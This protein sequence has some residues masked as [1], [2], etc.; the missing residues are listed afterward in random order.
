M[1]YMDLEGIFFLPKIEGLLTVFDI[2]AC[3]YRLKSIVAG[4]GCQ[5]KG[6]SYLVYIGT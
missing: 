3:K 2:V 5:C 1:I 6:W 4:F